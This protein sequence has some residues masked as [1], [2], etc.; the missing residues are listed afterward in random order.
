MPPRKRAKPNVPAVETTVANHDAMAIDTPTA[1]DEEPTY[2]MLKDPWTDEQETSLFKG[3]MRWKPNGKIFQ[4]FHT[5]LLL[6]VSRYA[7][8]LPHGGTFRISAQPRV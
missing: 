8:T 7:Q 5:C 2:D 4:L 3:I 6:I 1:E